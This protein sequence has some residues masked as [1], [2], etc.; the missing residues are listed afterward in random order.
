MTSLTT[1]I[2]LAVVADH[3]RTILAAIPVSDDSPR[4]N[5]T[6]YRLQGCLIAFSLL[7]G[8]DPLTGELLSPPPVA[9]HP[10]RPGPVPAQCGPSR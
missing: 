7:G 10:Q 9:A 2:D 3:L 4:D 8:V 5:P 1:D 6:R